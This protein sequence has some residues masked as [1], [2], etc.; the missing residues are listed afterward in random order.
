[1]ASLYP[2]AIDS[3]TNPAP[4]DPMNAPSHAGEHDLENDAIHAVE[5][6][7]GTTGSFNFLPVVGGTMSGDIAMGTNKI[8]GLANGANPSDAVNFSQLP[9]AGACGVSG[10]PGACGVSGVAGTAGACGV[11]GVAGACGVSGVAGLAGACGVSGAAGAC[12]VSGTAGAAGACGVS[13]T[14]GTPGACGVSGVVGACGVSGTAGTNGTNGACGV[15]GVP[16]TN[17]ACGVSGVAG[18][19]GACGVS[20]VAG[21][22][23]V[24]GVSGIAGACGVSGVAGSEAG[25]TRATASMPTTAAAN[26][27]SIATGST[28]S[29][30]L[31]LPTTPANGTI[32]SLLNNAT[33]SVTLAPG[34][35]DSLVILGGSSASIVVPPNG[36]YE[37]IY[38]TSTTT[39]YVV[40][41]SQ[42]RE[43]LR[44]T[45][46]A[47]N[48]TPSCNSDVLDG[49]VI[50]ALA[51][52]MTS[53]TMS[54][55]PQNNDRFFV[56]ITDNG[57]ARA[58]T[59]T[60]T[61]FEASPGC[62]LP[63]TTV[64]S[65][66]LK[67]LFVY[68][69]ATSKW[70]IVA[71]D[72]SAG[73]PQLNQLGIN[74]TAPSV[75]GTVATVPPASAT[76]QTAL[77]TLALGTAF[78]NTLSYDVQMTCYM[79]ITVD[80]SLVVSD[81]VGTTTTP[82]QTT[83]ITGTT[84][85]GIVALKVRIPAGYYRLL[86]VSGTGTEALVGQYLEAA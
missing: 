72:A 56:D 39:W 44:I 27:Y 21:A 41:G 13:G 77:G 26:E 22:C 10:I 67:C 45:S 4:T 46:E 71:T 52:A 65:T 76:V 86:S 54:G 51:A 42:Q 30:T 14:A 31:T 5:T 3:F 62:A 64:I 75:A 35:S 58:L 82:T 74:A 7:V 43:Q 36:Y 55:S 23:G 19:N 53:F 9:A 50:T 17:G 84:A 34:G 83:V 1:M 29:T 48:A 78:H 11:S 6:T 69:A 81:G 18:T 20:G 73:S 60:G 63:I 40:T 25:T 70:R 37:V 28:A 38:V 68:N 79:A 8:S 59:F 57:T 33:V 12:G 80:T 61:Y 47:S 85:L 32:N 66:T 16:G 2:G 15:A 24:S 49:H